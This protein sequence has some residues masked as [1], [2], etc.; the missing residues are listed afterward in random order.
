MGNNTAPNKLGAIPN[1]NVIT[2]LKWNHGRIAHLTVQIRRIPIMVIHLQ[3]ALNSMLVDLRV[4]I[5]V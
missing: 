2:E 3:R 4:N 1:T 5:E